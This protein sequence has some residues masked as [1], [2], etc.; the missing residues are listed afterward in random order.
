MVSSVG[1]S[2]GGCAGSNRLSGGKVPP[3]TASGKSGT[4]F[5]RSLRW[6][7]L[8]DT[9]TSTGAAGSINTGSIGSARFCSTVASRCCATSLPIRRS[10]QLSTARS[11]PPTARSI[12]APV[13]SNNTTQGKP[14]KTRQLKSSSAPTISVAPVKPKALPIQVDKPSP[15][16]PPGPMGKAS[17]LV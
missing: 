13:C 5:S 11:P 2:V 4:C 3:T 14:L 1:M 6:V 10:C 15:N 17:P 12:S 9:G 8:R 7:A 16:T